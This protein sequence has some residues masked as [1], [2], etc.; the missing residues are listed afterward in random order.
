MGIIGIAEVVVPQRSRH[1]MH[2][3]PVS[4]FVLVRLVLWNM[5]RIKFGVNKTKLP[6]NII[7][8]GY[9]E[10]HRR[11]GQQEDIRSG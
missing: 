11:T 9:W 10:Y 7:M 3:L 4:D 6:Y 5:R 2:T 8:M 1:R